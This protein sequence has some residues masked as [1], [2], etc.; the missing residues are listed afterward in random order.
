MSRICSK[1]TWG[2]SLPTQEPLKPQG[3]H[4]PRSTRPLGAPGRE[5]SK[6]ASSFSM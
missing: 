3:S 1:H 6:L 2:F 5:G 4:S